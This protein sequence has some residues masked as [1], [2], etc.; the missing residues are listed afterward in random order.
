ASTTLRNASR[1]RRLQPRAAPS[2]TIIP[3]PGA[4]S[5]PFLP[6]LSTSIPDSHPTFAPAPPTT[7]HSFRTA[8]GGRRAVDRK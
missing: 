1:N 5:A 7:P 6:A 4:H 2:P 8:G 3:Q